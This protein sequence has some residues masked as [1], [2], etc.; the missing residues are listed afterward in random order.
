[1]TYMPT[2]Q[3]TEGDIGKVA[4]VTPARALGV[5]TLV[6]LAGTSFSGVKDTSFWSEI[7]VNAGTVTA[8]GTM[9]VL[10]TNSNINGGAQYQSVRAGRYVAGQ[11]NIWR[12]AIRIPGGP[13]T[14]NNTARWGM[15]NCNGS[16]AVTPLN[17]LY[18]ELIGTTLNVVTCKAGIPAAVPSASWSGTPFTLDG[19]NHLYEIWLNNSSAY[20]FIDDILRHKVTAS[21]AT[22]SDTF[23][24]LSALHCLNT[25]SSATLV[26]LEAR[27]AAIHRMGVL[28]TEAMWKNIH[29]TVASTVLKL[30]AGRLHRVVVNSPGSG[31]S[32]TAILYDNPTVGS[33]NIGIISPISTS[34]KTMMTLEYG[35]PFFNGLSVATSGTDWDI[36]VVYE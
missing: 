5:A 21:T 1:M 11:T 26:T 30:S 23:T 2:V 6:R 16:P 19:N 13:G 3:I 34:G 9:V 17:G 27:S 10:S 22:M 12:G 8:A 25:A 7:L 15:F 18:F 35:I 36:T 28:G 31:N 4:R 29:G 33:N 14:A 24:L 32:D 20:F